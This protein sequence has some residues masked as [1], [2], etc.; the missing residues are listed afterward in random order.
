M[1]KKAL[2]N[3]FAGRNPTGKEPTERVGDADSSEIAR[4]GIAH[5]KANRF[6]EAL[7]C[8][9]SWADEDPTNVFAWNSQGFTLR[10]LGRFTEAIACLDRALK[11]DNNHLP[12]LRN[13]YKVFLD[14]KLY[15]IAVPWIRKALSIDSEDDEDLNNLGS[16][17]TKLGDVAGGLEC[18]SA[19]LERSPNDGI[20]WANKAAA[21]SDLGRAAESLEAFTHAISLVPDMPALWFN[22]GILEADLGRKSQ[23]IQSYS[24]FLV[25]AS[26][27]DAKQVKYARSQLSALESQST[28]PL[29]KTPHGSRASPAEEQVDPTLIGEDILLVRPEDFV[30]GRMLRSQLRSVTYEVVD[31]KAG[32]FGVVYI[33]K[34]DRDLFALKTFQARYLWKQEDRERFDREATTWVLLDWHPNICR[35][36]RLEKIE[37]LPFLLLEY[38]DGGDLAQLIANGTVPVPQ[39][40]EL[41]FQFCDA[42]S[43]AN[44]TRGIVHRDVKPQNCLLTENGVLKVTDFGLARAFG[45]GVGSNVAALGNSESSPNTTCVAGTRPYM[46]PEQFIQ[47]AELDT[48]TDVYSF[49]IMLFEMLT[50]ARPYDG[51]AAVETVSEKLKTVQLP[52]GLVDIIKSCLE[53]ERRRRPSDF[54]EL[55][56]LLAVEYR[57]ITGRDAPAPIKLDRVDQEQWRMRGD[58]LW[59]LGYS[60]EAMKYYD[61][62][63]E[64]ATD[65]TVLLNSKGAALA[66]QGLHQEAIR[67][68]DRALALTPDLMPLW[69]NK[70]KSLFFLNRF[71]EGL[72]CFDRG[73]DLVPDD[74]VLLSNKALLLIEMHRYEEALQLMDLVIGA[75]NAGDKVF[76]NKGYLLEKLNRNAEAVDCY[77]L[78][79]EK[80][81]LNDLLW[82]KQ[83]D[84]LRT[85]KRYKE[86]FACYDQALKIHPDNALPWVHKAMTLSE[87]GQHA[88]ALKCLDDVLASGLCHREI[89]LNRG[90]CLGHLGRFSEALTCWEQGLEKYPD[91]DHMW[92]F[93]GMNL[94]H[95]ERYEEALISYERA[96]KLCPRDS[97]LWRQ[98][99]SALEA[100]GRIDE[101]K[102]CSAEAIRLKQEDAG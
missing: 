34:M 86:A 24:R 83:G 67:E 10:Q 58:A 6:I 21:L 31:V 33:V 92:H 51:R 98:R 89:W 37:G 93:R 40:L 36:L 62:G 82:L 102:A 91:D 23:A 52:G 85:L 18:Y 50:T 38:V 45:Q 42:M 81:P 20:L 59:K 14:L 70:A 28:S 97:C 60:D 19:A 22:K 90:I 15:H 41:S 77:S 74:P 5:L 65:P 4:K 46:A 95:N 71:E 43:H 54:T 76:E 39:A 2:R 57:K 8:F 9:Q 88:D 80:S 1:F 47:G 64:Q 94:F 32:G 96:S 79:L 66:D 69:G 17:L 27:S 11:I 16:C 48:R 75:G 101:A 72:E 61:S 99:A 44:S 56:R 3:L 49:A 100:L 68:Y 12:S 84:C 13:K 87:L 53:T 26:A 29:T 63:I 78:A 25:L 7:R 30:V 35:P 55:R 73:L